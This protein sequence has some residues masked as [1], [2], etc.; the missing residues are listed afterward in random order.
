VVAGRK[1]RNVEVS[2]KVSKAIVPHHKLKGN[3]MVVF[4][5]HVPDGY[6]YRYSIEKNS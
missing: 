5:E 4:K 3:Q 1:V 2:R 6:L